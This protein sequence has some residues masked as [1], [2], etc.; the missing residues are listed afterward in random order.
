MKSETQ[1]GA[2][3]S[4]E[5]R[6]KLASRTS[7][8]SHEAHLRAPQA[9]RALQASRNLI[10]ATALA[11]LAGTT[12]T[13]TACGR[14]QDSA[15]AAGGADLCMTLP[16]LDGEKW[17]LTCGYGCYAHKEDALYAIDFSHGTCTSEDSVHPA[18]GESV[19][20]AMDGCVERVR[21]SDSGYGNDVILSHNSGYY[22]HYAH[23]SDIFV[24]EGDCLDTDDILGEVGNSG[25][26]VSLNGVNCPTKASHLHF[27]LYIKEDGRYKSMRPTKL[28]GHDE[29]VQ[30]CWYER[31]GT[32]YGGSNCPNSVAFA[33]CDAG[34]DYED[35]HDNDN[36]DN[37]NDDDDN[38]GSSGSGSN[39]SMD[40]YLLE[41]SP[42]EG[43]A[44]ETH[45][46]WTA[47]V[48]GSDQKPEATLKI[49]NPDD[50]HT[51][52]FEM[53]TESEEAPWVFNYRKQLNSALDYKYWVVAENDDDDDTTGYKRI[54]VHS[55]SDDEPEYD[56]FDVSPNSGN[57]DSTEFEWEAE[58]DSDSNT[59]LT[60]NIVNPS[61]GNIYEFDMD[62]DE[63]SSD[64]WKGEYEKTLRDETVYPCWV[65]AENG[66]STN[67]S[68]ILYVETD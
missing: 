33:A 47:V 6:P 60:L 24:D 8:A 38:S 66:D 35:D 68:K 12:A 3:A 13:L 7:C 16:L 36:D 53:E 40:A 28:S 62:S 64:H 17:A 39:D 61:D 19:T 67:T 27:A 23:L 14:N 11:V 54:D 42:D 44:G 55:S 48:E 57:A 29:L 34:D 32:V 26:S 37:S 52:D 49:Y 56:D 30:G 59:D 2:L 1:N 65:V 4:P 5:I 18:Y 41:V 45:F 10:A 43:T 63:V 46:I 22:T 51:Y 21:W 25:L 20:P 9:H 50:E 15:A 31:D 58:F